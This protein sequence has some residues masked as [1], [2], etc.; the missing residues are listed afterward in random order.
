MEDATW[1]EGRSGDPG[2]IP[3]DLS[4]DIDRP[5]SVHSAN[6]ATGVTRRVA[7]SKQLDTVKA[8][9]PEW[10]VN[11]SEG[12]G[13]KREAMWEVTYFHMTSFQSVQWRTSEE[14]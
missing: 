7:N 11:R 3:Q 12:A 9:S 1:P 2:G 10:G 5:V 14:R 6:L 4:N 13:P 8:L